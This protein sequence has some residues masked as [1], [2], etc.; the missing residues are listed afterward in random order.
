MAP[1]DPIPGVVH[2][3][4][5]LVVADLDASIAFDAGLIGFAVRERDDGLALL[6]HD[7]MLLYL[8][9]QSPLRAT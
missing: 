7:E 4:T 8:I 6:A 5:M 9:T 1:I 2:A 3:A